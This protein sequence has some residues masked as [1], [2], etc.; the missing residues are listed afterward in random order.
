MYDNKPENDADMKV[1]G[2]NLDIKEAEKES[3]KATH[4]AIAYSCAVVAL[5]RRKVAITIEREPKNA[6]G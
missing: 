5:F 6:S 2:R 3:K 1:R 4:A